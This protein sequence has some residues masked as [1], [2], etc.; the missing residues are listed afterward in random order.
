MWPPYPYRAGFCVTDDTDAATFEQ[1]KAV[2]DFLASQGFRTTKT[3]WPFRPVDRCGIPPLPDSTLRGVTLEDPRYLDYCK[4]LHAQ[5]F[6][7]CLHGASAGNNP[8]ARTQQALEFLER[9]LPG[10]DT[11]ICHSK[12]ADNIYWEHRIVSLPVLR[13]LVRRYSKHACSGENE[14]S[15]YFWGDLCQ[16]KINQIRLFRTRCRNTLQRNPSMPYFDRRKPYVN[17][18]FSATKRRLSDCAEPRAVADLKRD[19][20]LTVLYQ[21][22][23]RYARPDTLA[24][25]P[26]FRDAIATLA[27]DPEILIDTVSRLMRRLRLVQ[28]LFLIYRRHQFWLVNT[29]DQD[30]PQV[31]VALSGRLSRVGGDA[32]A[33]ICA[34]RLVLPVIR[35]SALVS[36]QTAEPLHFTGSRCKRLNR[37]QRGTFPTPRGTLLVNGSAS[38]W[39]RGDGLTVAAN[40]WSWEPPSSPADW[41]ARSRLPIGEELGLTLDQI[42]IIAREILFKGRSLNP[43]V[44][45]DDTKEIKLEDHNN[46]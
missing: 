44:F 25:D 28:G 13:R 41:T 2:Y 29:N 22:R 31:Q 4:A 45:L 18:W 7:I 46:W 11:F 23:H 35:A 17:G 37:R 30:V 12:N 5:G 9:H 6:E 36:V 21:Y 34:D 43:N 33:I 42:W 39:R 38:P 26:P 24:L 40:A 27:S 10:S 14:A 19:Y 16:R 15:P 20:G 32:G 8:R 3:V 1:V